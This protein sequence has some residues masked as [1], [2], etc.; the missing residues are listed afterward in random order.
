MTNIRVAERDRLIVSGHFG[1]SS[2]INKRAVSNLI[3]LGGVGRLTPR[4]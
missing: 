3:E 4:H 2:K 1:D